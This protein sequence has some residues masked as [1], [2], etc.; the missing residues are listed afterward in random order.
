MGPVRAEHST[1]PL[2]RGGGRR[3]RQHFVVG[4]C[5]LIGFCSVGKNSVFK[6]AQGSG[7]ECAGGQEAP[8]C[9]RRRRLP[10]LRRGRFWEWAKWVYQHSV[11]RPASL[12]TADFHYFG[13]ASLALRDAWRD[14][15]ATMP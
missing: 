10:P 2:L 1:L 14:G 6:F 11:P 7:G 8:K 15:E 13:E 4:F 12:E 3:L 5:P 9:R